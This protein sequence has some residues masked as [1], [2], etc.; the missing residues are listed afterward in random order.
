MTVRYIMNSY[1]SH[2][3][4]VILVNLTITK[5]TLHELEPYVTRTSSHRAYDD[6]NFVNNDGR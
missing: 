3:S 5:I 2:A 1:E 4:N 6:L